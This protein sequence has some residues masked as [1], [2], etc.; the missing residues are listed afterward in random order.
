MS[1]IAILLLT[2]AVGDLAWMWRAHRLLRPLRHARRWQVA[3]AVFIGLQFAGLLMMLASRSPG[4]ALDALVSRPLLA[5]VFIW[6]LLILLPLLA[7]WLLADL[8]RGIAVP[9]D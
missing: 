2:F 5:A 8:G 7:I 3:H 6:H 4:V 1:F 9:R